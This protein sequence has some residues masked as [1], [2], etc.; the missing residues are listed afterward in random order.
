[1]LEEISLKIHVF[2]IVLHKETKLGNSSD[3]YF[4]YFFKFAHI[5]PGILLFEFFVTPLYVSWLVEADFY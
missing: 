2:I 5:Y 4:P 3:F 1:M